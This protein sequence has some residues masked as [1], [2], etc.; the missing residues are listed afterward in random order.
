MKCLVS[1]FAPVPPHL[2]ASYELIC[3]LE[4]DPLGLPHFRE[5]II[6]VIM[7]LNTLTLEKAFIDA[8]KTHAP[9]HCLFIG[10]ARGRNKIMLERL[11]TNLKDF[12][13]ID[14]GQHRP[15]A[16]RIQG[17]GPVA[18]WSTLPNQDHWV[19][20]LNKQGIP[21]AMSNHAGNY[22]CNQ[23]LYQSLHYI[24]SHHLKVTC[25]FM[26][27]PLLPTQIQTQYPESPFMPLSMTRQALHIILES[28]LRSEI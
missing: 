5:L 28:L 27:I 6:P 15:K 13:E 19:D 7:P 10:Q 11:A 14:Q 8:L 23:L 20:L 2:N 17:D 16:E 4:K 1:G 26:H 22:L 21:A 24:H 12:T 3:S 18:Y 25:G 9:S